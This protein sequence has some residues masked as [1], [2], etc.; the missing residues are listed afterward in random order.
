VEVLVHSE[1]LGRGEGR[2]KTQAELA[3]ARQALEALGASG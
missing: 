2:N 3:A 1:V